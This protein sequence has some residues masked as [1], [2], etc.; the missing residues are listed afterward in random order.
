VVIV[1]RDLSGAGWSWYRSTCDLD[2][3]GLLPARRLTGE[4]RI[5]NHSIEEVNGMYRP[6]PNYYQ[7]YRVD[8]KRN[9]EYL[10]AEVKGLHEAD[11]LVEKCLRNMSASDRKR[12]ISYYRSIFPSSVPRML[13]R[14]G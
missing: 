14:V 5:D 8:Y 6:S 3:E 9:E 7:I 4:L 11:K 13:S 1:S 10:V 2:R 12:E